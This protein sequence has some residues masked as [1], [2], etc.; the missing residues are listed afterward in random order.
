MTAGV[1]ATHHWRR[2]TAGQTKAIR[3]GPVKIDGV[4]QS[5]TGATVVLATI[6]AGF[7]Y[8][9]DHWPYAPTPGLGPQQDEL[10]LENE[11]C[12]VPTQSANK[13]YV[14]WT[15][16]ASDLDVPGEYVVQLKITESGGGVYYW[17]ESLGTVGLSVSP[18]LA[19]AE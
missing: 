13:G 7:R 3:F 14:D 2:A 16:G 9:Y 8:G 19:S 17:P 6:R 15:P 5:L 11:A 4:T 10:T 12:V 18:R 1:S